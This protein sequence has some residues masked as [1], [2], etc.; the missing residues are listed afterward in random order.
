[1]FPAELLRVQ[2]LDRLIVNSGDRVAVSEHFVAVVI[3]CQFQDGSLADTSALFEKVTACYFR[4]W[5]GPSEST[6][7]RH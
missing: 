1:M 5:F 2:G 4:I 6:Q 7:E 3:A